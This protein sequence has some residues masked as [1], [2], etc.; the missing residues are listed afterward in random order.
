MVRRIL[1][2]ASSALKLHWFS[3]VDTT[4]FCSVLEILVKPVKLTARPTSH[5]FPPIG[6]PDEKSVK[7]KAVKRP[8]TVAGA[9]FVYEYHAE[10][11]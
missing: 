2:E 6:V 4:A 10:S 8:T 7:N 3:F 9:R 1:N 11:L 5:N